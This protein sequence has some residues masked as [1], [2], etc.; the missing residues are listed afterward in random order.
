MMIFTDVIF[1]YNKKEI[2]HGI[3]FFMNSIG[4]LL[5]RIVFFQF[6]KLSKA[7]HFLVFFIP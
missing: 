6:V 5:K 4:L 7:N 2:P 1:G 3:S